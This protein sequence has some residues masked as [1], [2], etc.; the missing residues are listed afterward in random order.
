MTVKTPDAPL[1]DYVIAQIN[2]LGGPPLPMS[3]SGP[4]LKVILENMDAS[5]ARISGCRVAHALI[6]RI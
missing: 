1:P 4:A 5:N 6:N 3:Q 2:S